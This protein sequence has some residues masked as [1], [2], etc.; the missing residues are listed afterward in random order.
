MA[1]EIKSEKKGKFNWATL[2]FIVSF[3]TL[4][5]FAVSY[6][7]ILRSI[8]DAEENIKAIEERIER[9]EDE[10]LREKLDEVRERIRKAK[11]ILVG[12]NILK[13]DGSFAE[14]KLEE[15]FN[16]L[17]D[18]VHPDIW[19][20]SLSF[21]AEKNRATV[22]GEALDMVSFKQ[23]LVTLEKELKNKFNLTE[24]SII[25]DQKVNFTFDFVVDI[26]KTI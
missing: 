9:G 21:D 5:F 20:T 17:A 12:G 14:L 15:T 19:F 16:F 3:L 7:L 23:Q 25:E 22:Q 1:I 13:E 24:Y 8:E 2:L 26:Q 10:E 4:L 6:F 11:D 18:N